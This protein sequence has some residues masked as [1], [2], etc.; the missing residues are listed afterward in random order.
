[1]ISRS[2]VNCCV[3]KAARVRGRRSSRTR[4]PRRRRRLWRRERRP[5]E[6]TE[7]RYNCYILLVT[8]HSR[9][10]Q[11][12]VRTTMSHYSSKVQRLTPTFIPRRFL[13]QR[14]F[15]DRLI[16]VAYRALKI[17]C[18]LEQI[19]GSHNAIKRV[20]NVDAFTLRRV[21]IPLDRPLRAR[22]TRALPFPFPILASENMPI[23]RTET[24]TRCF[25]KYRIRFEK[26]KRHGFL[27]SPIIAIHRDILFCDTSLLHEATSLRIPNALSIANSSK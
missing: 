7:S 26:V 18:P 12:R 23:L 20:I 21:S 11:L 22:D 19:N 14:A 13:P 10:S 2:H 5:G 6:R 1:M 15:I 3:T 17:N 16:K 25:R 24:S 27:S 4:G 8:C 9:G